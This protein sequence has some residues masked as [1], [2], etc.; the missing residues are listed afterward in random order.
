MSGVPISQQKDTS[1]FLLS[2]INFSPQGILSMSL[3][4]SLILKIKKESVSFGT[5]NPF[6][7]FTD[8]KE[9]DFYVI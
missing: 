1:N 2:Q 4:F 8:Y 5:P 3:G 6:L 9:G 7:D